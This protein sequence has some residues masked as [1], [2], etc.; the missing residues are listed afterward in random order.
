MQGGAY[1]TWYTVRRSGETEL[2]YMHLRS[3]PIVIARYK[4]G[5]EV[6]RRVLDVNTKQ[7]DEVLRILRSYK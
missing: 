6:S 2:R 4:H 1:D 7:H 5:R 3:G